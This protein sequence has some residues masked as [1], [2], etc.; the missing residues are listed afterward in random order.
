MST[1][2]FSPFTNILENGTNTTLIAGSPGSGKTYFLLTIIANALMMNQK[3]FVIDP[4]NDVAMLQEYFPEVDV[5]DVNDIRDGSLDPFSVLPEID[6]LELLSIIEMI[7]GDITPKQRNAASPV[8]QDFIRAHRLK[9]SKVSMK[10]IADA[11]YAHSNEELQELGTRMNG[12]AGTKY[13]KLIFGQDIVGYDQ[14]GNEIY[15]DKFKMTDSSKIISLLGMN[16][17]DSTSNRKISPEQSFNSSIVYIISKMVRN[18]MEQSKELNL[19]VMD[20]AHIAFGSDQFRKL[21]DDLMVLGRSLGIAV[22]LA[23]QSVSHYDSG[24][25]QFLCARFLFKSSNEDTKLFLKKFGNTEGHSTIDVENV[26]AE[27]MKFERGDAFFIDRKYR[28]GF[29]KVVSP[30][31]KIT[32]NPLFRNRVKETK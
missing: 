14:Y 15:G 5:I 28:D 16:L 31:S 11:F 17:P 3:V 18:I 30:M 20:E 7:A 10:Q 21:I 6:E 8:I 32:S 23:S 25:G 27:V 19:F 2:T 26:V 22:V 9:T 13:G 4:K 24:I 29:F 1:V 12:A